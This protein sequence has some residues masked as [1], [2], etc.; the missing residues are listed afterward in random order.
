[1]LMQIKNLKTHYQISDGVVKAVD[2]VS[3]SIKEDEVFGL[4][5]ESGCGK[6][7]LIRT[8]MRLVPQTARVSADELT[9]HG[10]DL[11]PLSDKEYRDRILWKEISLVPQSAMNSLNPVYRVGD[12]VVEA[13]RAHRSVG[14]AEARE[15][16][17]ELFDVVGL[18]AIA[19]G[20]AVCGTSV[21]AVE[22]VAAEFR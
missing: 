20:A 15:R 7:T 22:D 16:V 12:Q 18:Q 19:G 1:M 10:E 11:L 5:G 4:A 13:I 9:Y 17:A 3:I 6:S 8:I 2:G 21:V 14:K